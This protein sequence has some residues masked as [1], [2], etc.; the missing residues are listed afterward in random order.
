MVI[1]I[2]I[3]DRSYYLLMQHIDS[4]TVVPLLKDILVKGHLCNQ[5]RIF[6]NK[7]CEYL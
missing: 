2:S 3:K 7:Y 1:I 6:G 5:D 4:C